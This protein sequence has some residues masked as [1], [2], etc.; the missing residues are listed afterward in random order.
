ME[1]LLYFQDETGKEIGLMMLDRFTL[2]G[3]EYALL[4]SPKD[5]PDGG[6]YVMR[7]DE[8]DGELAFAM[9]DDEEME[10]IAPFLMQM[11]DEANS[12]C[13]HDC[14]SCHGCHHG[15]EEEDYDCD[16]EDCE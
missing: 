1:D 10:K 6:I 7:M 11:F 3:K 15:D 14:C 4:A 16:C 9:P 8:K 13:T 12:G 2:E 5:E